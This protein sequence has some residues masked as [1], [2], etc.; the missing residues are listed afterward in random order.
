M[1]LKYVNTVNSGY[2]NMLNRGNS[3]CS[4][5]FTADQNIFLMNQTGRM[6]ENLVL[7]DTF[8]LTKLSP[9]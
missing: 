6:K 5:H 7:E 9:L 8:M 3:G 1:Q 2:K 4:G